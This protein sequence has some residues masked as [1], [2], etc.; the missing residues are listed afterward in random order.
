MKKTIFTLSLIF[1]IINAFAGSAG[2]I[3]GKV[4]DE[5]TGEEL[6]GAN[7]VITGTT[8]GTISDLDGNFSLS[9]LQPGVY[10]ITCSFISY[11]SVTI[12]NVVVKQG[13]EIFLNLSNLNMKNKK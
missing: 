1:F 11:K 13:E 12:R 7:I 3:N 6:P 4:I 2:E 5:K 8:V 10:D 9:N